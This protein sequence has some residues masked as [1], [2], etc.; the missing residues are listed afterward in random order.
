M[1]I[2]SDSELDSDS[3]RR[4]TKYESVGFNKFYFSGL[5]SYDDDDSKPE[6]QPMV[7]IGN[8][9]DSNIWIYKITQ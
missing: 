8:N 5:I 7:L 9:E 4:E 6:E 3:D 1:K 2:N